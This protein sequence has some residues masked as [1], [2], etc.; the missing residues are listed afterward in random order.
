MKS[1]FR[2]TMKKNDQAKTALF[3]VPLD[4]SYERKRSPD[5]R[6]PY[7]IHSLIEYL[8]AEDSGLCHPH[9]LT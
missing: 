2:K 1:I 5:G 4:V 7:V 8:E 9:Q 6:L 3:G